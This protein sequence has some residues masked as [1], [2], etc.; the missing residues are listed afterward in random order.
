MNVVIGILGYQGGIAEHRY[1]ILEACRELGWECQ[2]VEVT[3]VQHLKGIDAIVL[4]GGES[5]TM[6]KLAKRFGVL[7]E[8]RELISKGLPAFG[9]CAGA[10]LLAKR[11]TDLKTGKVLE[12][13]IG[14]M[15][16]E[17]VRNYYGRQRESF[18]I[19]LHI[20]ALGP[21]PFRGVFIRAPAIVRTGPG[22][23]RL[24]ELEGV[25]VAARQRNMLAT[26]FHPELTG[27]TRFHR[28]FL[29]EIVKS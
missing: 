21:K 17:V 27:D 26:T 8:L 20:P 23:E 9:T 3:R 10:I 5:T 2:V 7:D 19:D 11:V 13:P 14:V 24:A 16:V 29:T 4:P 12:S 18:E 28:Y 15:D 22:V 6:V 1:M 25:V